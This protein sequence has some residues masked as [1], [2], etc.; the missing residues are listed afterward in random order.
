MKSIKRI[1]ATALMLA[2]V[3]TLL[4]GSLSVSAAASVTC[5]ST[6][7]VVDDDFAGKAEGTAVSATVAGTVYKG[8][9]GTTAFATIQEAYEVLEATGAIYVAPGVYAGKLE[10]YKPIALYG[11]MMN[12][13]P[14]KVGDLSQSSGDR[15]ITGA[16]ET[17]LQNMQI[18]YR[19]KALDEQLG[20]SYAVTINGFAIAGDSCIRLQEDR[21]ANARVNI[22]YN[23]VD[24]VNENAYANIGVEDEVFTAILLGR[25]IDNNFIA[26]TVEFSHNRVERVSSTGKGIALTSAFSTAWV[27]NLLMESNYIANVTNEGFGITQLNESTKILN[28]YIKNAGKTHVYGFIRGYVEISGNTFD[29]VGGTTAIGQ[30]ALGVYSE[31]STTNYAT[32]WNDDTEHVYITGNTFKNLGNALRLFGRLRQSDNPVNS[33]PAG[34]QIYDNIFI[35]AVAQDCTFIHMSYNN[36]SYAPPVYNNYTGGLNPKDIC[37]IDNSDPSAAF[38]F[39]DYW[40]DEEMTDCSTLLDVNAI[41]NTA[42][43]SFATAKI[44]T[45]PYCLISAAVPAGISEIN[46][47]LEVNDGA[48]YKLFADKACTQP[49]TD[50]LVELATGQITYAFAEVHY[51]DYSI[52]YT[53]LLTRKIAYS[54]YLGASEYV[55]GPEFANYP[56]TQ[57]VYVEIDGLWRRAVVGHSAFSDLSLA[58]DKASSGD[59]VYML[60]GRYG[61]ALMLNKGIKIRG[62]KAGINPNVM[63]GEYARNPER[64][65]LSEE[66]IF[67]AEITPL[68]GINGLSFDGVTFSEGG[69]MFFSTGSFVVE[70][71]SL[72][73]VLTTGTTATDSIIRRGRNDSG[74]NT[75]SNF[76]MVN[77]RVEGAGSSY[78][79]RLPN[80]SNGVFEGNV[81]R[82]C[83]KNIYMGGTD[84]S[85]T[86]VM[87]FKN[88]VFYNVTHKNPIY[89]GQTMSA[90][91]GDAGAK[92]LNSITLEGNKFINCYN[93]AGDRAIIRIDRWRAGNILTVVNNRFEGTTNMGPFVRNED[94]YSGQQIIMNENYFDTGMTT[95]LTNNL[96][97]IVAD[98]SY[99]YF[100]NGPTEAVIGDA[101]YIPYYIDKEMTKLVGAY[102][103]LD[104]VAPAGAVVNAENK[105]VT[106]TGETAVDTLAFELAV[107]EGATYKFYDDAAC[108]HEIDADAVTLKG[109]STIIYIK[110]IGEDGITNN[111]YTVYINQPVNS[112]AELLGIDV[113]GSVWVDQGVKFNCILPNTYVYGP[114]VPLMSAGASVSVYAANDTEL[115]TPINYSEDLYNPVGKTTYKIKVTAEDGSTEKVYEVSFTR[116]KSDACAL[117]GV[118]GCKDVVIDG[119]VLTASF[120]NEVDSLL[121]ELIVSGGATY[122]LFKDIG[123]NIYL[124]EAVALN[125][126]ENKI[127]AC[128]TAEDGE[129]TAV[130]TVVLNRADK[131]S[132]KRVMAESFPTFVNTAEELAADTT[133]ELKGLKRIDNNAQAVYLQPKE[134]IETLQDALV[135]SE[136]ASYEIFKNYDEVTGTF[137]GKVS[138]NA[139]QK[140]LSLG[141][142]TNTFYVRINAQN[143]STTVYTLSVVNSYLN[144]ENNI[145]T[146]NGF[147]ISREGNVI[148]AFG[149]TDNP[150]I[151]I[152][153]S[154][155]ATA[156]VF[157]DRKKTKEIASSMTT[158]TVTET[159][160]TFTDCK[161]TNPMPQTY[162]VLYVEVTSQT[163]AK[164]DYVIKITSSLYSVKFTDIDKHWAKEYIETAYQLGVTNG[165]V[166]ADGTFTFDPQNKATRE[167]V[168]MFI[169]N[170]LGVD[171]SS[172]AKSALPY[173]DAKNISSWARNA[174]KAATAMEIMGGDG[175]N[176]NPKANISRQEFMAV[177]VRAAALDTSK[178]S[179][180]V[181][182]NFKDKN[183]IASW[184]KTYVAT[185]VTFGLVNGDDKGC[186]NPTNSITRAEIVK[187]M[188]CAK[189]FVR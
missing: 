47:G 121:P 131:P 171:T 189:D 167:Q 138:S 137:T 135:V 63:S 42:G 31:A 140:E 104:V 112:N 67:A 96:D 178:A 127:Y 26:A 28:N 146:V 72:E 134:Y 97:G 105:T 65:D 155:N 179:T 10:V 165:S 180:S 22:S 20:G 170:L 186:I 154:N 153:I 181:L 83:T 187:I 37:S 91:G 74:K 185:A 27:T 110:V 39:G 100:A 139:E 174:V 144:E 168:A 66:A 36:G 188:V 103:L 69:Y 18:Y 85:S 113:E 126:G 4:G 33:S 73:N 54:D 48:Y 29:A 61:N 1:L 123:C 116:S 148:S 14:N 81:F 129:T 157:A 34:A 15:A 53:I 111:V 70:N 151:D 5:T 136:G 50:G 58:L 82:D 118:E 49:L 43:V 51:G 169:C 98:C 177:M 109:A 99:N 172:Y 56:T 75:F 145:I 182:K 87:M 106:Y 162:Y 128:V 76:R 122:E 117:T 38:D 40:L 80:I 17:I 95:V 16:K 7:V 166:H 78:I 55:V 114:L 115:T 101:K 8:T 19:P 183:A 119:S 164:A 41:T 130:Y 94:G 12:V 52:V 24:I 9:L 84:G 133:G 68:S 88:N 89:V 79:M 64:A 21:F 45:A 124:D 149:A 92:V 90:T 77:C 62:P 57:V 161:L 156:K 44:E 46:I 23:V 159:K 176:F 30:F 142:G 2:M 35:P 32:I 102:E 163:G 3:F 147:A 125:V 59:V 184:A 173:A 152:F 25:Q 141:Q 143:G 6:T 108:T 150:Q 158:Y 93:S 13:S 11:N 132:E 60:P 71:L 160:E 86:D 175:K 107:S 120:G